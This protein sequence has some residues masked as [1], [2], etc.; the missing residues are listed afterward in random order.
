MNIN[1]IYMICFVIGFSITILIYISLTSGF[2]HFTGATSATTGGTTGTPPTT[3]G[4]GSGTSAT[5]S[6]STGTPPTTSGSGSGTSATTGGSGSGTSASSGSGT[7]TGTG[8]STTGGTSTTTGGTGISTG[9][10]TSGASAGAGGSPE[11]AGPDYTIKEVQNY[12]ESNNKN[13]ANGLNLATT[14]STIRIINILPRKGDSLLA[15]NS[16]SSNSQSYQPLINVWNDI[17]HN[18]KF[19]IIASR[20]PATISSNNGLS[21]LNTQLQGPN[22]SY[23]VSK[24]NLTSMESFTISFYAIFNSLEPSNSGYFLFKYFIETPNKLDA[25]ISI[26]P[27]NTSNIIILIHWGVEIIEFN[28][29]KV[30]L[31]TNNAVHVAFVFNKNTST[32][33]KLPTITL[34]IQQNWW[35]GQVSS[36]YNKNNVIIPGNTN[37]SINLYANIN[38]NLIAFTYYDAI[39]SSDDLNTISIYYLQNSSG[40]STLYE[41]TSIL[42]SQNST[43]INQLSQASNVIQKLQDKCTSNINLYNNKSLSITPLPINNISLPPNIPLSTIENSNLSTNTKVP[44]PTCSNISIVQPTLQNNDNNIFSTI[45]HFFEKL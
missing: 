24:Q 2:E 35:I 41:N 18:Q 34:F 17:D 40:Y 23:F 3:S 21:L 39:L 38:L 15:I 1:F 7:G 43:L 4:S 16:F 8:A 37:M 26:D 22:S 45:K 32:T 42:T 5:T 36:Q 30:T 29:P 14:S 33:S 44:V 28:I 11:N 19:F 13:K 27:T 20:L 6:G 10:G 12:I 25:I 31:I 9:A